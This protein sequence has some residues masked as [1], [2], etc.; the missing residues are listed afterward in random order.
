[1]PPARSPWPN[2]AGAALPYVETVPVAVATTATALAANTAYLLKFR[3]RSKTR[4]KTISVLVGTASGN[5]DVGIYR[6]NGTTLTRMTSSGATAIAGTGAEQIHALADV[7]LLPGVDYYLAYAADNATATI[8]RT[9]ITAAWGNVQ[10][11]AV[12]IATSYP[13]PATITLASTAGTAFVVALITN[14]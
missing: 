7:W 2:D 5:A 4:V 12:A 8:H 9:T 3:V 14:P 11:R 13:L 1:M 6:S 10:K